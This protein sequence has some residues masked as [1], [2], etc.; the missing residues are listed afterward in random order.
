MK[1]TTDLIDESGNIIT[2]SRDV[3][4]LEKYLIIRV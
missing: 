3:L 1:T 2:A 4:V